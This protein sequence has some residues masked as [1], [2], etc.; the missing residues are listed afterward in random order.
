MQTLIFK[1]EKRLSNLKTFEAVALL[2]RS[3]MQASE[4]KDPFYVALHIPLFS[5]SFKA[6]D[7]NKNLID[8]IF[9][10]YISSEAHFQ[11]ILLMQMAL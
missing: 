5:F 2:M 10:T 6:H 3:E 11:P 7:L 1:T 9:K 8:C 4:K